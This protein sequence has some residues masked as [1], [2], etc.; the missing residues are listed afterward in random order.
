MDRNPASIGQISQV[1]IIGI[2]LLGC[3]I[4]GI[5]AE[6]RAVAP[7]DDRG[8]LDFKEIHQP[9]HI[10]GHQ[11]VAVRP[12]VAGA[13]A[14][15]TT[16]HDDDAIGRLQRAHLMAPVIRVGEPAMQQD[17]RLAV[18]EGGFSFIQNGIR[19]QRAIVTSRSPSR[20]S[21]RTIGI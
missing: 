19:P 13:T 7:A 11:I 9:D 12:L 3:Y 18:P 14:V 6:D 10:R 16:V 20:G 5:E 4:A 17:D 8:L 1:L 2:N 21:M 15:T